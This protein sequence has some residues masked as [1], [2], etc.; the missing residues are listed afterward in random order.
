MAGLI[1]K[2]AKTDVKI[3]IP[4]GTFLDS[5]PG[6][7][8]VEAKAF[9]FDSKDNPVE[10]PEKGTVNYGTR[11]LIA[12]LSSGREPTVPGKVKVGGKTFDISNIRTLRNMK[13]DLLGYRIAL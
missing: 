4:K 1:G 13:G 9:I 8:E 5:A 3:Y 12:P 11:M 7:D 6:F 10:Y 2:I